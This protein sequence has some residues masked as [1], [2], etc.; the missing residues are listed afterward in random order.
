MAT[1]VVVKSNSNNKRKDSMWRRI[2]LAAAIIAGAFLGLVV[3]SYYGWNAMIEACKYIILIGAAAIFGLITTGK[4]KAS[5]ETPESFTN[6]G[7]H[8]YGEDPELVKKVVE[9][10]ILKDKK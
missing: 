1:P 9:A 3:A 4:D 7:I 5:I 8:V 2:V 6:F 10:I